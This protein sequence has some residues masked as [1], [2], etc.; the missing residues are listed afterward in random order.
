MPS[1]LPRSDDELHFARDADLEFRDRH[2]LARAAAAASAHRIR[3]GSYVAADRWQTASELER[4][5]MRIVAVAR[6][7]RSPPI[8]SHWSAAAVLGLPILGRWPE[9]VHRLTDRA[10][11]GRSRNGV[12]AHPTRLDR[13]EVVEVDGLL[14]TSVA[15][16]VVD[17]ATVSSFGSAVT[18]ADFT[19]HRKRTHHLERSQ[20]LAAWEEAAPKAHAR[21]LAVLEFASDLA[22]SPAESVSRVNIHLGGLRMP[23]LQTRYSDAAGLIGDTDFDWE[24]LNLLGEADGKMKYTK[25]EYLRGRHPGEV[26]YAE[27]VREDRLRA[28]GKRVVRW[29]WATAV[30]RERLSTLLRNAGVP[31]RR[32]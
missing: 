6:T 18:S 9:E 1:P 22:D 13:V 4:Y 3:P 21:S 28:L 11:G 32:R 15:R 8:L 24:E 7:R 10:S 19:L 30:H 29:D 14:M 27:K 31:Q 26:V 5:R 17:L 23:R 2:R 25:E 12:I 16:T 20:L